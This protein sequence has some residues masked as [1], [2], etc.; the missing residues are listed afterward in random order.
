MLRS[1][2][3]PNVTVV[4]P[5]SFHNPFNH[6]RQY[7]RCVNDSLFCTQKLDRRVK[8]RCK[9]GRATTFELVGYIS[10]NNAFTTRWYREFSHLPNVEVLSTA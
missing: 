7:S 2:L 1:K 6:P 4:T 8:A 9:I 3:W 5:Q 10:E